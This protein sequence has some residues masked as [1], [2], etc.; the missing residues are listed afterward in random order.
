MRKE[1][2]ARQGEMK[3]AQEQLKTAQEQMKG[4]L[5]VDVKAVVQEEHKRNQEKIRK[6]R[7]EI[8]LQHEIQHIRVGWKEYSS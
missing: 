2:K 7:K 3:A 6:M 4:E 8:Q 5:K 1:M